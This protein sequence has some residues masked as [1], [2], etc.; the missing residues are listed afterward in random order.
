MNYR[1]I[2][3]RY[4]CCYVFLG[5]LLIFL[6][7]CAPEQQIRG[8]SI[9]KHQ[10]DR[11]ITNQTTKQEVLD[12]LGS[13][14]SVTSFGD[15]VW[16]YIIQKRLKKAFF[17][18]DIQEYIAYELTFT[19][20]NIL[21]NITTYDQN[22]TRSIEFLQNTTPTVGTETSVIQQLLGNVGKFNT[23]TPQP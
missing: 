19:E 21:Q 16:Y 1:K 4:V 5:I 2:I 8:V 20:Q 6:A 9:K 23:Q 3:M 15:N 7:S 12:I 18:A 11:L 22:D 17:K 14:S 13:P 10:L